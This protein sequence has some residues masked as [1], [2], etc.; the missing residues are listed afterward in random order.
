MPGDMSAADKT[1]NV[2]S[3]WGVEDI[4]G[5]AARFKALGATAESGPSMSAATSWLPN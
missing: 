3:Y 5:E 4:D 2:L 1:D